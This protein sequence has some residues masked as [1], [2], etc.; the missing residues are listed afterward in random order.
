MAQV[1]FYQLSRDPV[2]RVV[3]LLAAKALEGG[4]KLVVVSAD[5]AQRAA[6]SQSLWER[7]NAFLAHGD[8]NDPHAERQPVLLAAECS[9]PNGARMVLIADGLWRAEAADFERAILLFAGG[10]TGEARQ[11]WT[12]L[13]AEGHALRIFKQRDDGGW[14]EGR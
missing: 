4:G 2:E 9:A 13:S 12:T 11:L 7:E 5:A 1:D 8:A 14:R 10:Q 6:L 3:P